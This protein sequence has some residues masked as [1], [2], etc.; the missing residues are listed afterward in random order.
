[1]S[2]DLISMVTYQTLIPSTNKS[3]GL[4]PI[5]LNK[6]L[7]EDIMTIMEDWEEDKGSSWAPIVDEDN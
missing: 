6:P 7:P 2:T 4:D 5:F 1:M 3:V